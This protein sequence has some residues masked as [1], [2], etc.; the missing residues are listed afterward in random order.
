VHRPIAAN[1]AAVV[2]SRTPVRAKLRDPVPD[3]FKP[4][5]TVSPFR[6]GISCNSLRIAKNHH[7]SKPC[8]ASRNCAGAGLKIVLPVLR[9]SGR[10]RNA[11]AGFG[12]LLDHL[13]IE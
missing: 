12:E 11:L 7:L 2:G 1:A 3:V 8:R 13:A 4:C 10:G 6:E 5:S 9:G